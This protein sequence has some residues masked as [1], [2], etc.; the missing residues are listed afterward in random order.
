MKLSKSGTVS[1][2]ILGLLPGLLGPAFGSIIPATNR[3]PLDY[4]GF[5]DTNWL[6]HSHHSPVFFTNI[7]NV[8]YLGDENALLVDSTNAPAWLQYNISEGGTNRLRVDI[9]SLMF[10]FAAAW[11][12]TNLGGTGPEQWGRL[13]EVGSYTEDASYGWWSLYLNQAGDRLYFSAH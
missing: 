3:P 9:G 11:S 8:P 12:G 1:M 5:S 2:A 4:W 13:I 6:S 7:V 10:W